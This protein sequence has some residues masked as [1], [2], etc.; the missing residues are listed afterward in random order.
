M[1]PEQLE[2]QALKQRIEALES[3]QN[4]SANKLMMEYFIK[5]ITDVTDADVDRTISITIGAGGGTDTEQI[6]DYPD[7]WIEFRYN[8]E[9][10]RIGAWLKRLDSAR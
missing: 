7:K 3:G 9:I 5:N 4:I 10:F 2:I 6:L 8:G 1:K